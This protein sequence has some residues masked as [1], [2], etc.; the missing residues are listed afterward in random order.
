MSSDSDAATDTGPTEPDSIVK[1]GVQ[2][3][4]RAAVD[5]L[6]EVNQISEMAAYEVLVDTAVEDNS[7]VR[8]AAAD[9]LDV[10]L[11]DR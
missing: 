11:T 4:I 7:T 2:H 1:P 10:H 3:V 8:E 9:V 6:S 5:T